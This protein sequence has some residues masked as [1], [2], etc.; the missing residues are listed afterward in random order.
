VTAPAPAGTRSHVLE[1][2]NISKTFGATRAL[3][4]V[5][6]TVDSG[7]VLALVGQN[8]CG[9]STL[10]KILSGF[11][12]PD[13]G[14]QLFVNGESVPLPL[15]SGQY[16]DLGLSFVYQDLG[17]AAGMTVLE[18]LTIGRRMPAVAKAATPIF[19]RS[20]YHR[21]TDLFRSYNVELDPRAMV[22]DLPPVGRAL[23]AIVRAAEELR[24]Y[25]ERT[26]RSSG[27]LVLDEPT[28][29]LPS[30]D[31]EFLFGLVRRVVSMSAS[32]VFISHDLDA[33]RQVADRLVVMRDG[34]VVHR[35]GIADV[36]DDDIV[37]LIVGSPAP[38]SRAADGIGEARAERAAAA[39]ASEP[40]RAAAD[41]KAMLRLSDLSGPATR[42]VSLDVGAGEIVGV[43]GLVGSGS[44]E[45]PY[46]LFGD[47]RATAGTISI[48]GHTFD[49]A[50]ASP[51]LLMAAGMALVPAD[52]AK[53]G[54]VASLSVAEN[55]FMLVL[56]R[57][58][59]G[60]LLRRQD[61]LA[62]ARQ[63]SDV[64]DIR[65]RAPGALLSTLSG[66]NQQKTV[67]AKWLEIKPKVLVLH[68][69]TQGVDVGARRDL[70]HLVR[71]ACRNQ[72]MAVI[73]VTTDFAEL[74]EM[75]DRVLVMQSGQVVGELD[76]AALSKEE[77]NRAVFASENVS[78]PPVVP[79]E[80]AANQN[81]E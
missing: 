77:I 5:D 32:V 65:P 74:A 25:R 27:V 76:Q 68:E 50:R 58:S 38:G 17:L 3:R 54:A 73:W 37:D 7:E 31:I 72:D 47:V 55:L 14:G 56:G 13:P 70:Y 34:Q 66:G 41:G 61:M 42:S 71:D 62:E 30:Q 44:D 21:V 6:L 11:H 46:L 22:R 1:L 36:T 12:E 57:F 81:S 60:G 2:S 29:F 16:R 59:R 48:G 23:L 52:R 64:F 80:P 18:N 67:L 39:S 51:Q 40:P 45:L 69:P 26:G 53:D 24:D 4:S 35:G 33:I 8:G 78:R 28:V 10:V 15:A 9:K 75:C 20:E 49:A 43:A 19:W 63:R 79:E